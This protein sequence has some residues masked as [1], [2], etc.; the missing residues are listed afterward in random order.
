MK[1]LGKRLVGV[2][3]VVVCAVWT[4]LV[5]VD[6]KEPDKEAG[7]VCSTV[8]YSLMS[9]DPRLSPRLGRDLLVSDAVDVAGVV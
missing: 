4:L 9:S 3:A 2:V 1:L 7:A 5:V 8:W 6:G